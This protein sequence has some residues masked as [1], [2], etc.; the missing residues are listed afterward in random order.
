[1]AD[2]YR[3]DSTT[4]SLRDLHQVAFRKIERIISHV[5]CVSG[6]AEPTGSSPGQHARKSRQARAEGS[7]HPNG[8]PLQTRSSRHGASGAL[9]HIEQWP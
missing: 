4:Q 2:F 8:K 1:M 6:S 9:E 7:K 5:D 3:K